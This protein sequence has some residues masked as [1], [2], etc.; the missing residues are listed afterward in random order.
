MKKILSVVL[1]V[2]LV[3]TACTTITETVVRLKSWTQLSVQ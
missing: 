3:L 2:V 1:L